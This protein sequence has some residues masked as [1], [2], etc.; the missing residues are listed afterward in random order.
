MKTLNLYKFELYQTAR[1]LSRAAWRI[2]IQMPKQFQYCTGDQL[3][4]S[5]DSV[6][7]NIAEGQGRYHY[8]DKMKFGFN[9]RGSL[10]EALSWSEIL[11][12]RELIIP[13]DQKI[14]NDLC[15]KIS[16]QLNGHIR[17]LHGKATM[18]PKPTP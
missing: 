2:Y 4:R 14:F 6:Q 7:A 9:A 5:A 12:E 1:E 13:E 17:H 15:V 8:K 16:F 11:L 18:P 10:L 3:L